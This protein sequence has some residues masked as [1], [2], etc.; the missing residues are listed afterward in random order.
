MATSEAS[1]AL[2]KR[3]EKHKEKYGTL[4]RELA[5]ETLIKDQRN[6]SLIDVIESKQTVLVSAHVCDARGCLGDCI[7]EEEEP[8]RAVLIDIGDK[9]NKPGFLG[10]ER[11]STSASKFNC[12]GE[13]SSVIDLVSEDENSTRN[14]NEDQNVAAEYVES[15][16]SS[17]EYE[18]SSQVDVL[19]VQS[20]TSDNIFS[21]QGDYDSHSSFIDDSTVSSESFI[22]CEQDDSDSDTVPPLAPSHS[23]APAK[24]YN[25]AATPSSSNIT[26][27]SFLR[28]RD[29]LTAAT[30]E[31]FDNKVFDGALRT[32]SVSWSKRL[33]KTA[34]LTYLKQLKSSQKTNRTAHIEL[35]CKVVDNKYRLRSTL[36]H[37]M[38]HAA[39]W[40]ID[41]VSSPPHG[42]CFQKWAKFAMRKVYHT[43]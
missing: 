37:E 17:E 10:R 16:S 15:S 23:N 33:L 2:R 12:Q 7:E 13:N 27:R 25:S 34:G 19:S 21:G 3:F 42:S 38:C 11:A 4:W 35:S 1:I 20:D 30:F 6:F 29:E 18:F 24:C 31:E 28:Q 26:R 39:A 43:Q 36:L 40:L 32:V 8:T 41:S 5:K 22:T 14:I 9:S